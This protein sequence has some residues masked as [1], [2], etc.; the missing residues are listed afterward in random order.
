MAGEHTSSTVDEDCAK[1]K[2]L[3]TASITGKYVMQ[4]SFQL[5]YFSQ[6]KPCVLAVPRFRC[7]KRFSSSIPSS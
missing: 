6:N 2:R 5:S 4:Y 3:I 1:V 7:T